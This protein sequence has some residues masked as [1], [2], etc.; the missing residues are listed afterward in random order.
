MKAIIEYTLPDEKY[1][2][3]LAIKASDMWLVLKNIVEY[4]RKDLE[5]YEGREMEQGEKA[6]KNLQYKISQELTDKGLDNLIF[7]Y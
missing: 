1:E 7:N 6:L 4:T 3:E 5:F 2:H